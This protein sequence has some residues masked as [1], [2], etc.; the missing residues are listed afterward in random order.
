VGEGDAW[1]GEPVQAEE[2]FRVAAGRARGAKCQRCW[3][4]RLEVG[5]DPTHPGL[6]AE[7]VEIL[8]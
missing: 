3:R 2:G 8:S 7:C 6:C 1:S 4:Y 5:Q